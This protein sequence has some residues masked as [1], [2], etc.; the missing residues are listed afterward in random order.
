MIVNSKIPTKNK[1][2]TSAPVKNGN[3]AGASTNSVIPRVVRGYDMGFDSDDYGSP[4][5][6]LSPR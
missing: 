1:N 5:H 2:S 4:A 3:I 6:K